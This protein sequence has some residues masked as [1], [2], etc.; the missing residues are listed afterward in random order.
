M[1]LIW[2]SPQE[3][4][5][6]P[7]LDAPIVAEGKDGELYLEDGLIVVEKG[8]ERKLVGRWT[9]SDSREV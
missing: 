6:M 2:D 8:G 3:V 7:A 9:G 1:L 4:S 5:E